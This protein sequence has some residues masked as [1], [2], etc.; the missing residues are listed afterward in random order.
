MDRRNSLRQT[1]FICLLLG[2]VTL[3]VYWPARHHEFINYDDPAYVTDNAEIQGG[4]SGAGLA[5]AFFNLHG[6]STYWHPV[7]WVSHMLDCQLF[8]LN[9]GAHHLV[10]VLFHV[11]NTV[12]VFLLLNRMTGF[13]WRSAMVAAL[14]GLHP[15]QVDTVAWVTERK[16][17]LSTLFWLLTMLAYARYVEVR[18]PKS[19][20]G[21]SYRAA[22][23]THHTSRITFHVSR[24]T[25]PSSTSSPSCVS[26]S[27]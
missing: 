21:R 16:N 8:G 6:K 18:S 9:P 12:L 24:L 4:I 26:P 14:F 25:H 15:L 13:V 5:W 10:N 20:V 1:I 19:K 17:V 7:T 11:A 2:A 27:A 22:S 23:R 3:A